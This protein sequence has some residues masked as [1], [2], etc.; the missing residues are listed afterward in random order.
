M[1]Q[2]IMILGTDT[3]VGKTWFTCALART[4]RRHE[5]A[6]VGIKPVETGCAAETAA[7]EDGVLIAAATG[8]AAPRAALRRFEP[9]LAPILAAHE[10]EADLEFHTISAEIARYDTADVLLVEGV[11]GVL[12]PVT[13]TWN[14]THLARALDCRIV[15]VGCDRLG[16]V[17]HALLAMRELERGCLE[18]A[19]IVLNAPAERDAS[20]GRN[21]YAIEKATGYA[22]VLGLA[23]NQREFPEAVHALNLKPEISDRARPH[24]TDFRLRGQSLPGASA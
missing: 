13:W 15:L 22:Q 23:R 12:S 4:L 14:M 3:G 9:P 5:Q 20:T 18:L 17:N 10:N 8:Q 2:R 1:R 16:V 21:A 6:V 19:A 7:R 24:A 11:G